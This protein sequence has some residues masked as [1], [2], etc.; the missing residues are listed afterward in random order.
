[1]ADI[2]APNQRADALLDASPLTHNRYKLVL[3]RALVKRALL[4][5]NQDREGRS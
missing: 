2:I 5:V 3:A 4:Q 1:M